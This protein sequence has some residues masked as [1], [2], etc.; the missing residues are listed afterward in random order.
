MILIFLFFLKKNSFLEEDLYIIWNGES[1]NNIIFFVS[2]E[3]L[4]YYV[5]FFKG[6]IIWNVNTGGYV[7]NS[8]SNS[9]ISY[10]PSID[11]FLYLF[12]TEQGYRRLSLPIRDLVFMAPFRAES[13]EIFTSGKSTN[14][15]FL[16]E[17]NGNIIS[18]FKSISNNYSK[19]A[20]NQIII[21]RVDYDLTVFDEN[22]VFVRFS[23]F[24]I[25]LQSNNNDLIHSIIIK[26][27]YNGTFLFIINNNKYIYSNLNFNGF[28]TNIYGSEG[29]FS[30][31]I[32]RN[33]LDLSKSSVIFLKSES[34]SLA[35][36]SIPSNP[37]SKFEIIISN[38]NALPSNN[39]NEIF[40]PGIHQIRKPFVSF[41]QI[42]NDQKET[43]RNIVPIITV[44]EINYLFISL[45]LIILFIII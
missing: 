3:G 20:D 35:F 43:I 23:E 2:S 14:V 44:I 16:N 42:K 21:V 19:L 18:S 25:F 1:L 9:K 31:E 27:N 37:P 30:F 22:Q 24:D 33:N 7:Y 45:I 15:L 13:G 12:E 5:D 28:I 34:G 17:T 41:Q 11:G 38:L 26:T 10:I 39:N 32:K 6:E 36:P 8:T 40:S 29:K 4:I